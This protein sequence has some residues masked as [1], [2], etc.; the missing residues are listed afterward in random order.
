MKRS[1]LEHVIRAAATIV[2]ETEIVV[3]GSQA[4][5]ASSRDIPASLTES[6]EADVFP[7]HR[8]DLADVV[9]GAIGEGSPFHETFGYYA[10][11]VGPETAIVP[12]GWQDRLVT[13]DG[14]ALNGAIGRC[15]DPEDLGVAK[16]AAGRAKDLEFVREAIAIGL[17]SQ[18]VLA[19]RIRTLDDPRADQARLM[20]LLARCQ[21]E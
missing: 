3:I 21:G 12:A 4:I 2:N 15:L 18:D 11:G 1:Q 6:M 7:L 17:M 8:P 14:P 5:L 9:D 16:L 20:G 10:H 19:A 13:L